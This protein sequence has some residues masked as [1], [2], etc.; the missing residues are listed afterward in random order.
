MYRLIHPT[1]G[2][3]GADGLA[4]PEDILA[5]CSKVF[6]ESA[7]EDLREHR[8]RVGVLSFIAVMCQAYCIAVLLQYEN[9]EAFTH[10]TLRSLVQ[11]TT[12]KILTFKA[13]LFPFMA[14]S[15]ATDLM[16]AVL[17]SDTQPI[18]RGI[19][20]AKTLCQVVCAYGTFY[21]CYMVVRKAP[22]I[23]AALKDCIALALVVQFDDLVMLGVK[24]GIFGV[25]L[26]FA[27]NKHGMDVKLS[28][29]DIS[30]LASCKQ[31]LRT[32]LFVVFL[33]LYAKTA[34]EILFSTACPQ[35]VWILTAGCID[36]G[37][38]NIAPL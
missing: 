36:T 11:A 26:A 33:A 25:G 38:R 4:L 3:I 32:L 2:G 17:S 6:H 1:H 27:V 20:Y 34:A 22:D 8:L 35:R 28:E 30:F 7:P 12:P 9:N 31:V 10:E 29:Q 16:P 13:L 37:I 14:F 23:E 15:L 24:A 21:L 19:L 18:V 5:L